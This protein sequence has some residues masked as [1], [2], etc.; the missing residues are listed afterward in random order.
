MIDQ[1]AI[2]LKLLPVGGHAA[3][4]DALFRS[5]NWAA[6]VA[7]MDQPTTRREN[8]S[9]TAA[10]YNQPSTVHVGKSGDPLL[11]WRRGLELP[12]QHVVR[13][14]VPDAPVRRQAPAAWPGLQSFLTHQSLNSMKSACGTLGQHVVPDPLGTIRPIAA[15]EAGLDLRAGNVIAACPS[16]GRP[17]KP[18]V[19]A[20]AQDTESLATP[21]H[22]P[23]PSMFRDKAE[24]H[25][26][27]FAK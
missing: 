26:D 2:V 10:I 20:T 19:K 16:A 9:K 27:S 22:R 25:I 8:R 3:R 12:I 17:G 5:T 14:L 24:L 23:D 21:P 1:P 15:D 6:I 13:R 4:A 18:G 7:L 11:V